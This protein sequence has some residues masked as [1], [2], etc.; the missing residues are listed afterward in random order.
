MPL[1]DRTGPI[2]MGPMT[3][4]GMGYCKPEFTPEIKPKKK[5]EE[6]KEDIKYP[7]IESSVL[8]WG[9]RRNRLPMGRGFG[10]GF[11]WKNPL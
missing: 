4:R 7:T 11:G 2:G 8:R 6:F 9:F 5:G 10:R 3:G 1:R